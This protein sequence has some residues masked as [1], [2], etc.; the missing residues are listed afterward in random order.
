VFSQGPAGIKRLNQEKQIQITYRFKSD[1]NESKPYLETS[2]RDVDEIIASLTL[3]P[4]VAV[5]AIHDETDF[6]EFYFLIGA[7]FVLIYMILASVF[8]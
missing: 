5:E 7:A 1:V 2:R 3:P 8:E 6:S 4:G